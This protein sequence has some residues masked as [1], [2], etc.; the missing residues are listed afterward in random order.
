MLFEVKPVSFNI[1]SG[2]HDR[3]YL[4]E[5]QWNDWWEYRTMYT[6]YYIDMDG[7]RQNIGSVKIGQFDMVAKQ[8]RPHL[9]ETFDKLPGTFFS[10]GQDVSYYETLNEIGDDFRQHVLT[11]LNDIALLPGMYENARHE[12][13]MRQS[14]MRDVSSVSVKGQYRRLANGDARLTKYSFIYTAPKIKG[15]LKK[16][17]D[18]TFEVI[19]ESNP[20][21]NI[22]ILIGRNGVGK[23]HLLNNMINSLINQD[24]SPSK[25]GFFTSTSNL[26]K[27]DLFANVVFVSFSAFDA[28]EPLPERRNKAEGGDSIRLCRIKTYSKT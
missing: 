13:V 26:S 15:S 19:P 28:A 5:D 22:H 16:P 7:D 6:V 24:A 12:R 25:V 8:D 18:L 20:P 17:I 27:N 1:A 9:P 4:I 14:I 23:T 11:A 10:I 3:I 21:T 2:Y